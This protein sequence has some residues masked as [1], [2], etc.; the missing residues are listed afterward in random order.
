M[1]VSDSMTTTVD[2]F[3]AQVVSHSSS[4]KMMSDEDYENLL[5]IVEAEAGTEDHQRPCSGSKRH[6]EPYQISGVSE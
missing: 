1:N 4:A 6:Y 5:Q 2:N 3:D